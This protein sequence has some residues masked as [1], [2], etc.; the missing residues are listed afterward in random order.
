LTP[1]LVFSYG[2]LQDRKV[3]IATFGRELAG[4][5]DALPG[6]VLL[7]GGPGPANVVP[8]SRP[9]DEVT[10]TVFAITEQELAAADEYEAADL[11]GRISVT[12]RSGEQAWVYVRLPLTVT[13]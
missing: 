8:G 3:Q 1:A 5:A 12:L 2:S 7:S 9:D 4:R 6:Y 11:Y 10:G 13:S